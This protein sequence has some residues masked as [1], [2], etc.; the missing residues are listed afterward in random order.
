MLTDAQRELLQDK[1]VLWEKASHDYGAGPAADMRRDYNRRAAEA[2]KVALALASAEPQ[3]TPLTD[4]ELSEL[5]MGAVYMWDDSEEWEGPCYRLGV[6]TSGLE[7][8]RA[9]LYGPRPS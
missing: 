1:F 6:N 3:P 4:A 8:L 2:L 5:A 7:R 9:K